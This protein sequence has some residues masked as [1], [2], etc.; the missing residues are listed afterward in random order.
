MAK[1]TKKPGETP[2]TAVASYD[3]SQHQ[4][5]GFEQVSREDLGIPFLSIIQKGS[6]QVDRDHKE[7]ATKGIP[8]A[9]VGDII[10]TVSNAVI[11]KAGQEMQF[12]P[13]SYKKLFMEWTPREKGGGL[14]KT[15]TDANILLECVKNEKGQDVLRSGNLIVTTAYFYG[16]ALLGDNRVPCVIGLTSTQLKKSKQWLNTATNIKLIGPKGQYTPPF[17]SHGYL[18]STTSESNA[19]GNWRGWIIKLGSIVNDPTLIVECIDYSKRS[20]TISRQIEAPKEES[21]EEHLS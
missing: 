12:I 17:Y 15:H 10:N 4:S 13:C 19:K 5:A 18:L 20:A 3:F 14:V 1:E 8:G 6:P 11:C 7:Y 16:V 2:A 21:A 9:E